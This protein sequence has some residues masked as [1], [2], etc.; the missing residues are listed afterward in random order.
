MKKKAFI[1]YGGWEGH[2]PEL[3]SARFKNWLEE[4]GFDVTR[5]DSL[6]PLDDADYVKSFDLIVPC[7]TQGELP[8]KY[9]FAVS[10][11]VAAGTGLAGVHGGMCDSFRWSV[12]WQYMT[13]SQWV[14]HPGDHYLHHMS[15]L[16]EENIKYMAETYPENS[17][18]GAF[19]REYT[20]EFKKNSTSP[21]IADIP[22]FKV[23]T[24]QY[25]LHLDPACDVLATTKVDSLG[26]QAANGL[27]DMPVV[28]TKHWGKGRVFYSSLGHQDNILAIP[29]V[30]ELTRRGFLWAAR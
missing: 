16:S 18:P 9:C 17:K 12:E 2:E 4:A 10:D 28:Y 20:V 19:W 13:G 7:W 6:E 11:A 15:K 3:E 1:F 22:D 25:Y 30:T 5:V 8:D 14:S 27:V 24:E 26:P 21:L 29:E 23:Y